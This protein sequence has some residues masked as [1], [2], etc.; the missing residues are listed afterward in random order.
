M[1]EVESLRSLNEL[2]TLALALPD[3]AR[4][5]WLDGL[6]PEQKALAPILATLLERASEDADRFMR[7]PIGVSFITFEEITYLVDVYRGDARPAR[8]LSQYVLFLTLFPH[9]IAGPIFRWKDL[10]AQLAD[11]PQDWTLVRAGFDRFAIGLAKKVLLADSVA[12]IADGI[13]A[14]PKDQVTTQLA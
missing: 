11:R 3:E 10:E 8:R 14:L 9:S 4:Q 1:L 12:I 6:P 13:F 7:L 2:L 5:A